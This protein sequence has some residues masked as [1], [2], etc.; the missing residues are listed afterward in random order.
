MRHLDA[1]TASFVT[2]AAQLLLHDA[3]SRSHFGGRPDLPAD[4]PWP[5]WQGR[6]LDFLLR[7]SLADLQPVLPVGGLPASG[8]LL[9]FY[10]AE[11]QPWGFDPKDKGSCAVLHVPDR[12]APVG[13]ESAATDGALM[14]RR[15]IGLRRIDTRPS[16][17]NERVDGLKLDQ[18]EFDDYL[19]LLEA[20]FQGRP[21]HQIGG[22]PT[23][24]QNDSMQLECQLASHGLFCGDASGYE[25]PRAATL[26]PGAAQWRLLAQI[27]TDDDLGLMWGDCGIIYFWL[28]EGESGQLDL[29]QP[30]LI[31]QCG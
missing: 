14:P 31:L 10:A 3:P 6:P 12:A 24:L 1:L 30:W 15:S 26:Q 9:F 25:D 16:V 13:A 7:L 29:K 23:V 11:E 21:K 2:P 28:R 27:D 20:P 5:K 8:A 4:V 17:S 22:W 18:T 19:R